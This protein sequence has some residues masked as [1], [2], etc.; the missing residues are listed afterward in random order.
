MPAVAQARVSRAGWGN[1][2]TP[3]ALCFFHDGARIGLVDSSLLDGRQN[4][5]M[6]QW[7]NMAFGFYFHHHECPFPPGGL[8]RV[9]QSL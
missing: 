1:W 2:A 5:E 4:L 7:K 6:A 9:L 3:T 8:E